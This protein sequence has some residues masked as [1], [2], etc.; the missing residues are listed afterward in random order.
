MVGGG[1]ELIS[2][3]DNGEKTAAHKMPALSIRI[4]DLNK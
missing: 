3:A 1:S 4:L 2:D